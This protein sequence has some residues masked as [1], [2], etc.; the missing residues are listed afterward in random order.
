MAIPL[1]DTAINELI[2]ERFSGEQR[3]A[4]GLLCLV[5]SVWLSTTMNPSDYIEDLMKWQGDL[6]FPKSLPIEL[7]KQGLNDKEKRNS[8]IFSQHTL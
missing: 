4:Q 6:P 7:R 5:P 2:N 8:P 1:L 3:H